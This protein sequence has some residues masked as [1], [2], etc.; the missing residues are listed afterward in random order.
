LSRGAARAALLALAVVAC[1][2]TPKPS[3]RPGPA[4]TPV[5]APAPVPRAP[6]PTPTALDHLPGWREA[7]HAA[8]FA[9]FV[10]TCGVAAAPDMAQACRRA[11]TTPGLDEPRA[12]AFFEANFRAEP[13]AGEGMLTAYFAPEYEARSAPDG[14]FSAPLRGK[15]ADL[16][17]VGGAPSRRIG[18]RVEPYPDR[19]AIE[20][21]RPVAAPAWLR[22]EDLF[23]LQVQGSGVLVFPDGRRLKAGVAATNGRPYFAIGAALRERG[24]LSPDGTTA[25]SIRQWLAARRGPEAD[26]VMRLNPRYVFFTVAPDDGRPPAGAARIPLPAGHAVAVDPHA[27]PM[28]DLLWIDADRPS[29][30]GARPA[31]RRLVVALDVGAAIKGPVR[32]DLFLGQGHDAGA[33]AGT[34]RHALRLYRLTPIAGAGSR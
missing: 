32:A 8:A 9:A 7:D 21:S 12:K 6:A 14:E 34:V 17:M 33:E 27:H 31:Y 30:A 26:A 13:A 23:F 20:T 15:P 28:G 1:T 16:V 24:Q 10:S 18:G 19:T 11:R 4:P 29:L 5:P 3:P 25:E 22:P 2:T